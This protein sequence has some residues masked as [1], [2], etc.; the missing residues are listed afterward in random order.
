MSDNRRIKIPFYPYFLLLLSITFVIAAGVYFL[1]CPSQTTVVY[2]ILGI[3][4]FWGVVALVCRPAIFKEIFGTRK[5]LL[6]LND[7]ILILIVI[8]IGVLVSHIAF[9]R[10][11]RYDFTRNKIFSLSDLTIKTIKELDKEVK[12]YGFFPKNGN[13]EGVMIDLFKEYKRLNDK[14][15]WVMID[16]QIDPVT[17]Q[18]MNVS[19]MGTVIVECG[20]NKQT[21]LPDD[22]FFIPN[23][24]MGMNDAPKFTGEQAIT[25]AIAN[26]LSGTKR[27]VSFVTGHEESSIKGFKANDIAALNQLLTQENYEVVECNLLTGEIDERTNVLLVIAPKKDF[28]EAEIS[29]LRSFVETKKGNVIFAFD[30]NPNLKQLYDFVFKEF[31]VA[32][33]Y[34]IVV[35]VRGI[36]RNYWTVSPELMKHEITNPLLSKNLIGLMFYVCSL[37]RENNTNVK[38]IPLMTTIQNSWAKRGLENKSEIENI[39]CDKEIDVMGPLDVGI[40][41]EKT[42]TASGSKALILGDSDFLGNSYIAVSGN[43]DLIINSINWLAG[44]TK[45]LSIRPRILEMPRIQFDAEDSGKIFSICVFGAPFLIVFFGLAVFFYRRMVR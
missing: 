34:D 10:N 40:I 11:L 37:T 32:V 6:W 1:N 17:S 23:R 3:G 26:V 7:I 43:R 31:S 35:D 38:H 44:N 27:V 13:E 41:A 21:V 42:N 28:L 15:S 8:A 29:K 45:M 39:A 5:T 22:L 36:A 2:S 19:V 33:N 12:I 24:M 20:A 16:P 14:L 4:V 9:R 18:K 30:P 25:S